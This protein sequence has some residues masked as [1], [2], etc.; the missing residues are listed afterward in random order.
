MC[1]FAHCHWSRQT[2]TFLSHHLTTLPSICPSFLLDRPTLLSSLHRW[3]GSRT[4]NC[5][6]KSTR[7]HGILPKVLVLRQRPKPK[8][9][10]KVWSRG[11]LIAYAWPPLI[12]QP[13]SRANQARNL[14]WTRNK[15][16]VRPLIAKAVVLFCN[17]VVDVLVLLSQTFS[18]WCLVSFRFESFQ[19]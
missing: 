13:V 4:T 5:R 9:R 1:I 3:Q 14:F 15:W 16:V 17:A 18:D 2:C 6:G 10:P 7:H 11:R 12:P 8:C 19:Y